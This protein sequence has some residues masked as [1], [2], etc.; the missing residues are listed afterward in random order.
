MIK[1]FF[2]FLQYVWNMIC[3]GIIE[4]TKILKTHSL[5]LYYSHKGF[6]HVF[7]ACWSDKGFKHVILPTSITCLPE[8]GLVHVLSR[9]TVFYLQPYFTFT[10]RW[11]SSSFQ[12][13]EAICVTTTSHTLQLYKNKSVL[14]CLLIY[15]HIPKINNKL[16]S[17]IIC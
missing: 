7:N 13:E 14:K 3:T 16:I 1:V 4:S 10:G 15:S 9:C 2:K 5:A 17:V 8:N 12:I 11:T 6:G